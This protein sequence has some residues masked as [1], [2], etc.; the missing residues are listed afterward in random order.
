MLDHF[1]SCCNSGMN[2]CFYACEYHYEHA[3][4]YLFDKN[5]LTSVKT[6]NLMLLVCFYCLSV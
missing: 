1:S 4:C 3:M 6:I 2:D 5:A